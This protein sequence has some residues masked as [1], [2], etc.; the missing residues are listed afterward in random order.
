MKVKYDRSLEEQINDG[1]KHEKA[2]VVF[3][4]LLAKQK[5]KNKD[6]GGLNSHPLPIIRDTKSGADYA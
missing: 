6:W 3:T 5:S 2:S 4:K 1:R